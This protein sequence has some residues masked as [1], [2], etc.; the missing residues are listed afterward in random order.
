MLTCRRLRD[1]FHLNWCILFE[2][3][4]LELLLIENLSFFQPILYLKFNIDIFVFWIIKLTKS[5]IFFIESVLIHRKSHFIFVLK[6]ILIWNCQ[7]SVYLVTF[8]INYEI[9]RTC[10]WYP[11]YFRFILAVKNITFRIKIHYLPL[12]IC[13]TVTFIQVIQ[14]I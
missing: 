4:K 2:V 14:A 7:S 5:Y 12:Q 10:L 11:I 13:L 9:L 1:L 3:S 6:I 8:I